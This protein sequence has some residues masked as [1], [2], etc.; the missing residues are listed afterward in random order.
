MTKI[1]CKKM[2]IHKRVGSNICDLNLI[3]IDTNIKCSSYNKED[4]AFNEVK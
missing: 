4:V 3:Q 2:C 1:M